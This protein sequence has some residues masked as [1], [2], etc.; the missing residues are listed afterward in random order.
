MINQLNLS[1]RPFRNRTLPWLLSALLIG[2]SLFGYLFIWSKYRSVSAEADAASASSKNIEPQ[3]K[4][5][6][7][8][9][10]QIKQTLTSEQRQMLLAAHQ[11][12]DR[13]RFSWSRLLADLE[14]V[15]PSNVAVKNVSVR[16]VFQTTDRRTAAELD[17]AVV[18]KNDQSV[19]AMIDEMNTSGT[20]QAELRNQDLQRDKGNLTEYSIRLIYLPRSG[21]VEQPAEA[22]LTT[23]Q[24]QRQE[25][26]Q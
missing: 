23:A 2:V 14:S 16:D 3:I 12:V 11:L 15:L 25:V 20:F 4:E 8:R 17:F 7:S 18:S 24:N 1:S 10:E 5:L 26:A 6:R 19:L 21:V 9:G 22:G 13:K